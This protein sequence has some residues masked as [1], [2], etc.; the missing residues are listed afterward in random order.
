MRFL[1][2]G[3]EAYF[4]GVSTGPLNFGTSHLGVLLGREGAL[5]FLEVGQDDAP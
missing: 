2:I 4:V 3:L 1:H 5:E